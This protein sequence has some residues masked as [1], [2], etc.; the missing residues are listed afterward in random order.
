MVPKASDISILDRMVLAVEKVRERLRRAA[1]A[2][3]EAGVP[4]AIAGGNAVAAWVATVDEAAVRNTQDVDILLR[5][6]D[7]E[8]AAAALGGSGFVRRHVAGV[9]MFLDGADA[10][11]RDA[12]HVVM[13]N[14]KVRPEYAE[15]APDVAQSGRLGKDP[16]ATVLELEALVRMK[17]TSFRRKDQ[18][19]LLDMLEVGLID[20]SWVGRFAP[21]L[22]GR[23]QHLIETPDE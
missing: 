23:L 9:E 15:A 1:R 6:E 21:V 11:P 19:H 5:R 12:V 10:K 20:G 14:E 16:S 7:L 4:Y 8:R 17:L 2:L 22:A 18:V 3:D 13:A